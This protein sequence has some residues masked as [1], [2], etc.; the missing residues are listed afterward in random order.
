MIK[1]NLGPKTGTFEPPS[2]NRVED[3][4]LFKLNIL[5]ELLYSLTSDIIKAYEKNDKGKMEELISE[6]NRIK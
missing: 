2:V 5:Y 6:F 1:H 4:N 3:K